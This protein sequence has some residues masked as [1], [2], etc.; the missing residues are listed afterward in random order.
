METV[1][2]NRGYAGITLTQEQLGGC[3]LFIGAQSIATFLNNGII[4][5]N[6]CAINLD[7]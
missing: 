6:D 2:C 7:C 1:I 3:S 5:T 4:V